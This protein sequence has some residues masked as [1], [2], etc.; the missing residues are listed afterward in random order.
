MYKQIGYHFKENKITHKLFTDK[1][2]MHNFLTV[3]K[4]YYSTQTN[5]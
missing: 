2:Y 1:W 5:D 3:G 4:L